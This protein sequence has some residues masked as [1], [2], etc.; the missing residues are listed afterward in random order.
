MDYIIAREIQHPVDTPLDSAL[1]QEDRNRLDNLGIFSE[2][3]WRVVP[4]EDKTG[5]LSFIITES[6]QKIP[7]G[8]LPAYDEKTGWSLTGG[9][10]IQNFRGRN[11]IVQLGGSI[12]GK[13]TYGINF[14]DP[15][16]FGNHVSL[17]LG[18]GRSL[19]EHNFLD[20]DLDVRSFQVNLGRWFGESVKSSLGFE[21]EEKSFSNE[22]ITDSYFYFSP[23]IS[24]KYDTRDVYWN[25]GKGILVAHFFYYMNG[26]EPSDFS[27]MIWGQSYSLFLKLNKSEKKLVLALNGSI[28]RKWGEKEEEV[29]LNYFG[30]SYTVRGWALPNQKLYNSRDESFRFG[31]ESAYA[32]IELRKDIIPKYATKYGTE[33]G[34]SLVAFSDIGMIAEDWIDLQNMKPMVGCGFG[35]RV[36]IPMVDAIRIDLG[37]GYRDGEWNAPAIHWGIQQKF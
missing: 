34:L 37:W 25:P 2:V 22:T 14:A 27:F 23:Q 32:T 15:W 18:I 12:G 28:N 16:M 29:W 36:P 3:T 10:I 26:I 5:I 35:I 11:Q 31:H 24:I 21:L 1:V 20:R 13:Y 17:S 33:F 30:D 7:P 9:W 4:L 6:I 19:F 8:A